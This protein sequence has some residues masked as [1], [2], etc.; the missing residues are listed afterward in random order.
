[1]LKG[2]LVCFI[3]CEIFVVE[4]YV[5]VVIGCGSNEV[6]LLEVCVFFCVLFD[7]CKNE[8]KVLVV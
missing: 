6:V 4:I 3:D 2:G 5:C 1:M 7:V 8:N